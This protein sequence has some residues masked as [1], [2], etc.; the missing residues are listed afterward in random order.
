MSVSESQTAN[1]RINVYWEKAAIFLLV[2]FVGYMQVQYQEL[3][4]DAKELENKVFFLY[5]DKVSNQQLQITE[6][7]LVKNIEGMRSD[8]LAR[9]DL[10][11]GSIAKPNK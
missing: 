7:R 9:L 11:F 2:L 4:V 5:S 8:L 1:T 10:Y 6:D 3:K